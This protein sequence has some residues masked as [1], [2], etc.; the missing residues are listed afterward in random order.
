MRKC[1]GLMLVALLSF[2]SINVSAQ[3]VRANVQG[4]NQME[5]QDVEEVKLVDLP[6]PVK[7][8]LT[9]RFVKH[10]PIKALKAKKD[11]III[12]YIKLQQ[13]EEYETIMID[14]KGNLIV[15]ENTGKK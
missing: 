15:P 8:T 5:Q 6:E 12:Y 4:V 7:K 1:I 2:V 10:T 13:G 14:E 11:G 3:E 9:E